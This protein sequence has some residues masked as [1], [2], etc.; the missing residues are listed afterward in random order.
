MTQNSSTGGLR[1]STLPLGQG[2]HNDY[3]P[4]LTHVIGRDVMLDQSH[5]FI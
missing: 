4:A 1:P 5:A 2:F 3:D